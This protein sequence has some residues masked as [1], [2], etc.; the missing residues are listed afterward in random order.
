MKPFH[1]AYL[2]ED[3]LPVVE[4]NL[5]AAGG[6]LR[7]QLVDAYDRFTV[8]VA[9]FQAEVIDTSPVAEAAFADARIGAGE[10]NRNVAVRL[11]PACCGK[12]P[13]A[14]TGG[15]VMRAAIESRGRGAVRRGVEI[16][17]RIA[18]ELIVS[19]IVLVAV[20]AAGGG[21]GLYNLLFG[22]SREPAP[23][24]VAHAGR[25]G[26]ATT[27]P[28]AAAPAAGADA[29]IASGVR[30]AEAATDGSALPPLRDTLRMPRTKL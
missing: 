23:A 20:Q 9:E 7:S 8:A 24:V 2:S 27:A 1:K 25:A 4:L 10:T 12:S 11:L 16:G 28:K 14:K 30:A 29:K 26:D 6:V 18:F 3:G 17:R 5:L 21:P 19:C 13:L 22:P 15:F